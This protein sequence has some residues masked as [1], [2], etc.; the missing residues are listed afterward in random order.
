[1]TRI[2]PALSLSLVMMASFVPPA[3]AAPPKVVV[4][5]KP[6]HSLVAGVMDGVSTPELLLKGGA[7]PHHYA[8][9][10]S[11]AKLLGN[12]ELVISIGPNMEVFLIKPLEALAAK[13]RHLVAT[14]SPGVTT[15]SARSG[16]IWEAHAHDDHEKAEDHKD[17]DHGHDHDHDHDHGHDHAASQTHDP[18]IW[19]DPRN[20]KAIAAAVA[21]ALAQIDTENAPRYIA[22]AEK[23]A[24]RID[25]LDSDLAAQLAPI[26]SRPFIVFHDAY[27]Y[28]EKRYGLQALGSI[29]VTPEQQPGARRVKE[30][31]DKIVQVDA[32]CVFAE[33]Q[34]EPRLV[35][36]LIAETNAKSGT[37]DP[38][39]TGLAA[40][41]DLYFSLMLA[42][43][44]ELVTC[45]APNT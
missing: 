30:I 31:K 23:L 43:G 32:A 38:E 19:L 18:H 27:Q 41:P 28:F 5:I 44:R 35:Q 24:A 9:K 21:A 16:G 20:A 29:T 39:G 40:G 10:P 7:S 45:L 11:E 26:A 17:H 14:E 34:Y 42:I 6:L 8:L 37:L 25:A 22:N 15:L 12:A 4:S 1:M 33:P 3:M 13:T 36:M 2:F